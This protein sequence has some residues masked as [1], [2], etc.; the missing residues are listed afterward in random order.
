[1]IKN[2]KINI[3]GVNV[4]KTSRKDL[5]LQIEKI[6]NNSEQATI[7]TPNTD[8]I[9]KASNDDVLKNLINSSD[10]AIPDGIGVI[11][12]SKII[13]KPLD[14]RLPGIETGEEIIKLAQKNGYKIFLLGSTDKHLADAK[15]NLERKYKPLKICGLH[16]GYF[17]TIGNENECIIEEIN[18]SNADVVFVCMGFPRQ[19]IWIKNNIKK[20]KTVKIAIG[21][22]G[23]IDVWSGAQKRAPKAFRKLCLEWLWRI[24]NEIWR[25]KFLLTIPCFVI[26]VFMQR[27]FIVKND[28]ENAH[29]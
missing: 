3:L 14:E 28:G 29:I 16:N 17:N 10:I 18:S 12:A 2:E 23:S 1:M 21:L 20:L 9:Y 15:K 25:A 22:G 5:V 13:G 8:M 27:L 24:I 19:E 7:F 4:D 11:I 26:K 6:L